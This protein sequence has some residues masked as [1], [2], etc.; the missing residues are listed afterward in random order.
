MMAELTQ[1]RRVLAAQMHLT[2]AEGDVYGMKL[3]LTLYSKGA[4]AVSIK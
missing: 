2:R 3:L 1:K 4:A